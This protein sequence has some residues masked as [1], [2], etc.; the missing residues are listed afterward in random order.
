M[1]LTKHQK[2]VLKVC[3]DLLK[4]SEG[5]KICIQKHVFGFPVKL[6]KFGKTLRFIREG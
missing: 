2:N 1:K 6:Q 5:V 3:D 4:R